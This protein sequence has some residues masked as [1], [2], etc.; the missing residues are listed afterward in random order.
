M[1]LF[2]YASS[3]GLKKQWV[4]C[5]ILEGLGTR[6]RRQSVKKGR[7]PFGLPALVEANNDV[8]R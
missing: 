2:L 5:A 7:L 6:R 8:G 3:F 4:S 1:A